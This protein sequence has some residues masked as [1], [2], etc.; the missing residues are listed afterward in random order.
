MQ[1]DV[2]VNPNPQTR[3]GFPFIAVLQAD[4][5]ES[6][7]RIVAPMVPAS[8]LSRAAARMTPVVNLEGRAYHLMVPLMVLVPTAR[9]TKPVGT[10]RAHRDDI[11]R[12]ID[13]LFCG[14]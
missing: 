11:V 3:P 6:K 14:L 10:I 5:A 7:E 12:A 1:H 4:V 2:F 13:W 9:L 8:D